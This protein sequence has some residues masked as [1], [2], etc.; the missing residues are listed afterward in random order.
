[1]TGKRDFDSGTVSG[2]EGEFLEDK[3]RKS[4][5]KM[6]G[7]HFLT[8]YTSKGAGGENDSEGGKREG[9]SKEGSRGKE[10]FAG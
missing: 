5:L 6:K 7:G 8:F 9:K 3:E 10:R 2:R 4:L 1:M